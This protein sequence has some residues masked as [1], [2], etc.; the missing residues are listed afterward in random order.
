ML[1]VVRRHDLEIVSFSK[2]CTGKWTHV[3]R[4][5]EKKSQLDYALASSGLFQQV[6]RMTIDETC[7]FC[8]FSLKT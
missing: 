4:T 2:K 5:S 3:I 1:D 6:K 7:L 8:P